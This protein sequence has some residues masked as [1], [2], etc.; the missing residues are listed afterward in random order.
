MRGA[1]KRGDIVR[2][3][4]DPALGTEQRG[5]RPALVISADAFNKL[6]MAMLC[7]ITQGGDYARGL[8]WTVSLSN[9]GTETQGV[10]L[11]NQA[12][13]MDWKARKAERVESAP[14]YIT[15]DVIARLST[16]LE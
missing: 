5:M 10:V 8:Q 6:G 9:T 3:C 16:L 12:R 1:P 15:E 2:L 7:P 11:C 13:I 14:D 4:F